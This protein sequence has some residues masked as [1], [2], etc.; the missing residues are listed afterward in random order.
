MGEESR[1]VP[2]FLTAKQSQL[3]MS[4]ETSSPNSPIAP[5][6]SNWTKSIGS[7]ST[8]SNKSYETSH[9]FAHRQALC[10]GHALRMR[11]SMKH[12]WVTCRT[13]DWKMQRSQI[14]Y[15]T[16]QVL[17]PTKP[18]G[19]NVTNGQHVM[20]RLIAHNVQRGLHRRKGE[21]LVV[22]IAVMKRCSHPYLTN[23]A[24]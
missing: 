5:V 13:V 12:R 15:P 21:D 4:K 24:Q 17:P 9:P 23:Q 18:V 7:S 11:R 10:C 16:M 20:M 14:Y 2:W 19:M 8:R 3:W 1:G 22:Q 6:S